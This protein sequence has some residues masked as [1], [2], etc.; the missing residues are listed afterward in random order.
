MK[1][2][3][4]ELKVSVIIPTYR[5]K[6]YI[7]DC[8]NSLCNQDFPKA[9]YEVLLILNGCKDPYY[10]QIEKYIQ[11]NKTNIVLIQTDEGGVSNARNI[12]LD[13]A[14][15]EYITFVDDDDMLSSSFLSQLYADADKKIV[16]LC[17]PFAFEDSLDK[18]AKY[19]ITDCYERLSS[20]RI[21]GKLK[22][23][24]Y[25]RGPWM[26][27]IHRDIIG[28]RRFDVNLSNGEDSLFMY[29]ISDKIKYV[30]TSPRNAIYY[31]RFREGSAMS[32]ERSRIS[33]IKNSC[34]IFKE[35]LKIYISN[36]RDYSFLYLVRSTIGLLWVSIN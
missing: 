21:Y 6:E 9:D 4:S 14:K 2:N 27:L 13:I 23:R 22:A 31:R 20:G 34:Y 33:I 12:A 15:G 28:N 26:K 35:E 17:Y 8:L 5:P 1:N 36:P 29:L 16:P 25:F 7:W 10:Q 3:D 32:R 30:R 11:S 24:P 18:Q 19:S